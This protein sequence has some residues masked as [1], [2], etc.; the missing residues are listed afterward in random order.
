MTGCRARILKQNEVLILPVDR[1]WDGSKVSIEDMPLSPVQV[2]SSF[3]HVGA[4]RKWWRNERSGMSHMKT[5]CYIELVVESC[6]VSDIHYTSKNKL[7]PRTFYPNSSSLYCCTLHCCPDLP[8]LCK[9][10]NS[11][12]SMIDAAVELEFSKNCIQKRSAKYV[13]LVS[14]HLVL[15]ETRQTRKP[16]E[17]M[18]S[19]LN[20]WAEEL[21]GGLEF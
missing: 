2:G 11:F 21:S 10:S 14:L 9:E 5:T 19:R 13:L 8:R 16:K 17:D 20:Q 6:M 1:F 15:T 4:E 12:A 18:G 3:I 7:H